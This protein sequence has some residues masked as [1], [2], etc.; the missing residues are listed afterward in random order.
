MANKNIP[1]QNLLKI[2]EDL[3]KL[4]ENRDCADCGTKG[5][6]V[7][8]NLNPSYHLLHLYITTSRCW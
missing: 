5:I 8:L 3:L 4:P 2:L 6:S 1:Q 7:S